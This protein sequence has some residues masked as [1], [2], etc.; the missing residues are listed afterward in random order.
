VAHD[1]QVVF[2]VHAHLNLVHDSPCGRLVLGE[3]LDV[4]VCGVLV[5]LD[6]VGI[7]VDFLFLVATLPLHLLLDPFLGP[8]P[9]IDS[10]WELAVVID[11]PP[12]HRAVVELE[13]LQVDDDG[14]GEVLQVSP[15]LGAD[16]EVVLLAMVLVVPLEHV[17]LD[18]EVECLLDVLFVL[19]VEADRVEGLVSL[20]DIGILRLE[21][22]RLV[23]K[24]PSDGALQKVARLIVLA[25]LALLGLRPRLRD[26]LLDLVAKGVVK[27]MGVLLHP[28]VDRLSVEFECVDEAAGDEVRLLGFLEIG[29]DA[30]QLVEHVLFDLLLLLI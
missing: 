13:S 11:L 4:L 16:L 10:L 2:D 27:L 26:E 17:R 8:L 22:P 24:S 7:L 15:P 6:V 19:D 28:D 29:K 30:L 14:V 18:V 1:F 23:A 9:E 5:L 21:G 3:G 12:L 20:P 25:L